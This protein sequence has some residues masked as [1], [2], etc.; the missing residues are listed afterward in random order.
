MVFSGFGRLEHNLAELA[1][2]V[3]WSTGALD[4]KRLAGLWWWGLAERK[5]GHG[6]QPEPRDPG[7]ARLS[8]YFVVP[9]KHQFHIET[10]TITTE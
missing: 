4:G 5:A 1:G 2:V 9:R 10:V 3:N 8:R 7:Q 6:D